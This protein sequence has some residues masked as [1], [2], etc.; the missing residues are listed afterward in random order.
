MDALRK[1]TLGI[2]MV[3]TLPAQMKEDAEALQKSLLRQQSSGASSY[4]RAGSSI[5]SDGGD[6]GTTFRG[7]KMKRRF[8]TNG[9]DESGGSEEKLDVILE[10]PE[11]CSSF[12]KQLISFADMNAAWDGL[13]RRVDTLENKNEEF[14]RTSNRE[15][16]EQDFVLL[17]EYRLTIEAHAHRLAESEQRLET[18]EAAIGAI[19]TTQAEFREKLGDVFGRLSALEETVKLL[20]LD[21]RKVEQQDLQRHEEAMQKTQ[22]L[23]AACDRREVEQEDRLR[24]IRTSYE[25]EKARLTSVEHRV[26]K[27]SDFLAGEVLM[28]HIKKTCQELLAY[29][30]PW[31]DMDAALCK[32]SMQLIEPV[33]KVQVEQAG[34][35]DKVR[36]EMLFK[37]A[38]HDEE[39]TAL[40]GRMEELRLQSLKRLDGLDELCDTLTF[41]EEHTKLGEEMQERCRRNEESFSNYSKH[42]AG[43]L[44]EVVDRL[45]EFQVLLEDHEHAL[46]HQAEEVLNRATKYDLVVNVQ[47]LDKCAMQDKV[48]MEI[49]EL[50]QTLQWQTSKLE[51]LEYNNRFRPGG[52]VAGSTAFDVASIRDY[53]RTGSRAGSICEGSI[54]DLNEFLEDAEGRSTPGGGEAKPISREASGA[55]NMSPTVSPRSRAQRLSSFARSHSRHSIASGVGVPRGLLNQLSPEMGEAMQENLERI[56]QL[57]VCMGHFVLRHKAMLPKTK[58]ERQNELIKHLTGVNHL[59]HKRPPPG[60]TL[61]SY[62]L[63]QLAQEC[64]KDENWLFQVPPLRRASVTTGGQRQ[65]VA[66]VDTPSEY[67]SD[68]NGLSASMSELGASLLGSRVLRAGS[69]EHN[70]PDVPAEAAGGKEASPKKA[71]QPAAGDAGPAGVVKKTISLTLPPAVQATAPQAASAR[72]Q[73]KTIMG[74]DQRKSVIPTLRRGSTPGAAGGVVKKGPT[75]PTSSME[76]RLSSEKLEPISRGLSVEFHDV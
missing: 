17:D 24:E 62:A 48:D 64:E 66:G 52:S 47:R 5:S 71:A 65:S 61:D 37:D 60:P 25:D 49:K 10:D 2:A 73:R 56:S 21:L 13:I 3:P 50:Q 70:P 41:K 7:G 28:V 46:H 18:Q 38:Q 45:N 63:S 33:Q 58:H 72:G 12:L 23:S 40:A 34:S 4:S 67:G 74:F 26:K 57:L 6:I 53:S 55:G 68:I 36:E 30:I 59:V 54:A 22:E 9:S 32:Y 27:H 29:Y 11:Q 42:V 39:L 1:A 44:A 69:K 19:E 15:V 75:R 76:M 35:L 31:K 14:I 20:Q 51:T 8:G 43:K 16:L